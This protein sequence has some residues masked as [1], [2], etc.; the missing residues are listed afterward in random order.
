MKSVTYGLHLPPLIQTIAFGLNYAVGFVILH[1][2]HFALA[3]KQP[4]MTASTLATSLGEAQDEAN[5][6]GLAD[7]LVRVVRSQFVAIV[8]NVAVAIPVALLM[9]LAFARTSPR[10]SAI[11]DT[12]DHLLAEIDPR[13]S[14]ALMHAGIAGICLFVAGIVSGFADN[15]CSYSAV[16][17][18]IARVGWLRRLLGPERAE[19]LA[20]YVDANAGA[21]S[22][23]VA[24]G[25]MLAGV[26]LV[27]WLTGLPLDI[28]HVTFS[29]AN[30]GLALGSL[31]A[32]PAIELPGVDLRRASR[33]SASSTSSSASGWRPSSPC[34][35][36]AFRPI[37]RSAC[38]PCCGGG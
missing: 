17:A 4:A 1:L 15:A 26:G 8:G 3:T 25:F 9:A 21:L 27:G 14:Y 10:W 31:S 24:L 37:A 20:A 19:A 36:T 6:E 5:L 2:L 33:A 32:W 23:N 18:R 29:G 30:L 11:A 34:A 28:R 7:T 38:S 13:A 16:P 35:P 22:G 12:A